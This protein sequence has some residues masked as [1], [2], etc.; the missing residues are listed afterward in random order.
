MY[1][2]NPFNKKS[3]NV[4]SNL[5][6]VSKNYDENFKKVFGLFICGSCKRRLYENCD[7]VVLNN[8][9]SNLS[10]V[11]IDHDEEQEETELESTDNLKDKDYVC[12][13]VDNENRKRKLVTAVQEAIMAPRSKKTKLI[14]TNDDNE[15]LRKSI[16][17]SSAILNE[18]DD[19]SWIQDLK[20][21]ISSASTR[22]QKIVLLTTIP[23]KWS[24]RKTAKEF[25]VSRRMVSSARKLFNEKG[26][27][28][29][30]DK[31]KGRAMSLD[32]IKKVEEFYLSD[33]ISRVMP[34]IRDVKSV[35][36]DGKRQ[37]KTVSILSGN[38]LI[39]LNNKNLCKCC[40]IL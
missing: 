32:L 5:F 24:I 33:N 36:I 38:L 11:Q 29:Q 4:K 34:G 21:A 18:T 1:C 23:V 17:N 7:S 9:V 12:K 31:K 13:C 26:Y 6:Y 2:C 22:G 27:C 16:D 39:F 15:I 35:K 37:L 30:P 20:V 40:V 19:K 8:S 14:L 28:A 25:G 3:H 10:P